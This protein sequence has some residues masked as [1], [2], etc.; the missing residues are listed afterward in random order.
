MADRARAAKQSDTHRANQQI[1]DSLM[2]DLERRR[3]L[4]ESQVLDH[5][6]KNLELISPI[7]GIILSGSID[8]RENYPV[9]IGQSLYEIAP[10]DQLRVEIA[11]PADEVMHISPGQ[12]VKFRFDGF[13]TQ[14]LC[15]TIQRVRPSTTIRNDENVFIAEALVENKDGQIR[16]G[17]NGNARVFGAR[18]TIGWSL[19]HRPWERF[20]T[21]IGF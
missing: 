10:I 9:T 18:R 21:A 16:P 6:Q 2:A 12:D 4:A 14:S 15:G 7:D 8:R 17:M 5:Q 19:F 1:P 3:L 11:I 13:G 20:V